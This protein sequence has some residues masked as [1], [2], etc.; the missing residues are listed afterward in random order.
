[1]GCSTSELV[2]LDRW[3]L[4]RWRLVYSCVL[5]FDLL[6]LENFYSC[7]LGGRSLGCRSHGH[8]IKC[9]V[10]L[11]KGAYCLARILGL[12]GPHIQFINYR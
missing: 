6:G 7:V 5:K 8:L 4:F 2:Q 10:L 1:M 11:N 12:A 3:I 9:M